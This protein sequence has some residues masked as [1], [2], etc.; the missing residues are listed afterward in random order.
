MRVAAVM[1]AFV[2]FGVAL[3]VLATAGGIEIAL[4][5]SVPWRTT[6]TGRRN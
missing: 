2:L 4:V 6:S 5:T 1:Q 3:I